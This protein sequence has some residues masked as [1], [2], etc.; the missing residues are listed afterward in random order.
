MRSVL[1][2]VDG[3]HV[4]IVS[5]PKMNDN[6]RGNLYINRKGYHSIN[7]LAVSIT[8]LTTLYLALVKIYIIL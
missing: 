7:V 6:T 4:P 5:P 8:A 2:A 1:G 3:T